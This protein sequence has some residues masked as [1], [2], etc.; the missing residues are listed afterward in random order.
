MSKNPTE[1]SGLNTRHFSNQ[2]KLDVFKYFA[3][4]GDVVFL[5]LKKPLYL[6][7]DPISI[8]R[9][10]H[11]HF[12]NYTNGS[13]AIPEFMAHSAL[14]TLENDWQ[15]DQSELQV[16]FHSKNLSVYLPVVQTMVREMLESWHYKKTVNMTHAFYLLAMK[17]S[18][19]IFLGVELSDYLANTLLTKMHYCCDKWA[20]GRVAP[21]FSFSPMYWRLNRHKQ[22][23][24]KTIL[25]LLRQQKMENPKP[26]LASLM[27]D[28]AGFVEML[29][30]KT[31]F[32]MGYEGIAA[33][34]NWTGFLLSRHPSEQHQLQAEIKK[35]YISEPLSIDSLLELRYLHKVLQESMRL[36]PPVWMIER[37]VL[38]PD[39]LGSFHIPKDSTVAICAYTLHRNP[40]YWHN[41]EI[42]NPLRF[43]PQRVADRERFCYLP[44]GAGLQVCM[45]KRFTTLIAKAVLAEVFAH[46]SLTS[47]DKTVPVMASMSLRPASNVLARLSVFPSVNNG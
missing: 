44:F 42:F 26:F 31:I 24:E 1:I 29:Q 35:K 38:H 8:Q 27:T 7:N 40:T 6:L 25:Q 23:L 2:N 4:Q 18:A 5:P 28:A 32:W 43:L 13:N 14:T 34:L 16:L 33:M 19:R 20:S 15:D 37:V 3:N 21:K 11:T 22:F 45:G 17:I 36:Y 9:V 10:L 41:P 39:Q 47:V 12:K 30:L 46:Y